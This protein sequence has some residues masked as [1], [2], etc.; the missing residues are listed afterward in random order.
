[1]G[2]LR[3][4]AFSLLFTFASAFAQTNS[5]QKPRAILIN[6]GGDPTSNRRDFFDS[7][8]SIKFNLVSSGWE[9]TVLNSNGP[10]TDEP[11]SIAYGGDVPDPV[12]G[13]VPW[14]YHRD[15]SAGAVGPATFEEIEKRSLTAADASVP[16]VYYFT[17]HGGQGSGSTD[18]VVYLWDD[19]TLGVNDLRKVLRMRRSSSPTILLMDTCYGG[20]MLE[21]LFDKEGNWIEGTCGF[22]SAGADEVGFSKTLQGV[23]ID[24]GMLAAFNVR[25][26]S[27][28]AKKVDSD[29]DGSISFSELYESSFYEKDMSS[30][31]L[32]S[33]DFFIEKYLYKERISGNEA[34]CSPEAVSDK[35]SVQVALL[36][37]AKLFKERADVE[38]SGSS[39]EELK[40]YE[41]AKEALAKFVEQQDKDAA[42]L[43]KYW[44]EWVSKK[45]PEMRAR[46]VDRKAK[47]DRSRDAVKK[48]KTQT[49]KEKA[50][51][52]FNR[53][54]SDYKTT[55]NE[56]SRVY[57]AATNGKDDDFNLY[58][59]S[60]QAESLVFEDTKKEIRLQEEIAKRVRKV[61]IAERLEAVQRMQ[62]RG[63]MKAAS[64]LLGLLKCEN[65]K[66]MSVPHEPLEGKTK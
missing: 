59:K 65:T 7:L 35:G 62:A 31:P 1:M 66:L 53:V 20:G 19:E 64:T 16:L 22:A 13:R 44:N 38:G 15:D 30:S 60:K 48:A 46:F 18:R 50:Y 49:E 51:S 45:Y 39:L 34:K 4:I 36:G 10:N 17:D 27:A 23:P 26:D 33:S 43:K 25:S 3:F 6:G 32:S 12:D 63:D 47:L 58:L 14:I 57:D 28:A 61:R 56:Y 21:S 9:T 40:A 41:S 55:W 8:R 29:N 42:E 5:S 37:L 24:T 52:N 11:N 54:L 2:F